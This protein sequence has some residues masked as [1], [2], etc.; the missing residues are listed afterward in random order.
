MIPVEALFEQHEWTAEQLE[1][2]IWRATFTTEREEEYD[3]Y[4]MAT[5]TAVRFAVTPFVTCG[6]SADL[7]RVARLLLMLNPMIEYVYFASDEDGD[8][9]L[10]ADL[11]ARLL[12]YEIFGTILDTMTQA[13]NAL[14]YEIRRVVHEPDY[15]S[16]L[17]PER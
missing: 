9:M 10:L 7:D 3:L 13:T 2:G 5:A 15:H 1:P 8:I 4:V 14:A 17:L 6:E 16:P 12:D 11:S